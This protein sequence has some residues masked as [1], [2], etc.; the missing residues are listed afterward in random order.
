MNGDEAELPARGNCVTGDE[1][2][3]IIDVC[4][5]TKSFGDVVAVNGVA[6]AVG[7]GEV[8]GFLG[9]NGAGK[10]TT[11][12]ILV[13]LARA[14]AGTIRIAGIDCSR[15]PKGAQ[16]L[17]GV[18]PDESN[19]YP[20][21]TGFEN[22]CFCGALYGM[23]RRDRE[24]RGREL[25]ER[26]GLA[27]AG[28]RKFG[29]YSKGMKRK[30]TIAAGII[31]EPPILFLDEPTTGIDVA[32]AR[33]IR[34]II[35]GL[36]ASGTTIFITTHYIEEAQ[37]LC[38]R[39]AFIVR[40]RIVR[41]D[42]VQ[43]LMRQTEGRYVV[44]F[45]VSDNAAGLCEAIAGEFAGLECRAVGAEGIRVESSEPVRVG[46]LVRFL[47]DR[48]AEVSEARKVQP[49]LEEVFVE[50]TGIEAAAMKQEKEKAKMG[51]GA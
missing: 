35:T 29:G 40:G 27:E 21:L 2:E 24:T 20:E 4:G 47:E 51:G 25:L 32:S 37:R 30:L 7:R 11:I 33:H 42:T 36:N 49:S 43:N 48:G 45:A 39:I 41:V 13:G 31:H 38:G 18:I 1:V 44:Q 5:L 28:G 10:T 50:I 9:P 12:N 19:L 6:F 15:N 16:H 26:F 17:I 3:P 14:D 23:G 34:Q 8:F 46:P 22:L